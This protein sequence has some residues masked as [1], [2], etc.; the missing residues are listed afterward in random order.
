MRPSG[1]QTDWSK[2]PLPPK[3]MDHVIAGASNSNG[4]AA[5]AAEYRNMCGS[6]ATA[7]SLSSIAAD[8]GAMMGISRGSGNSGSS[9][10]LL[11]NNDMKLNHYHSGAANPLEVSSLR[12]AWFKTS[13][14]LY[15]AAKECG[16][17]PLDADAIV[18]RLVNNAPDAP[19]NSTVSSCLLWSDRYA[20]K[21]V[22]DFRCRNAN[23]H[24]VESSSNSFAVPQLHEWLMDWK[25]QRGPDW[26][27][28]QSKVVSQ[29]RQN[30][31]WMAGNDSDD[32]EDIDEGVPNAALLHG[33]PG[34]GKTSAVY[35]VASLL[36]FEVIEINAAQAR[37]G[38]AIQSLFLEATQS[39]HVDFRSSSPPH[40]PFSSSFHSLY[41]SA[42]WRGR[43]ECQKGV[44]AVFNSCG[45][46]KKR[47]GRENGSDSR[48]GKQQQLWS[49]PSSK[50]CSDSGSGVDDSR[51]GSFCANEKKLTLILFE[52]VDEACFMENYHT[53]IDPGFFAALRSMTRCAKC[54]VVM[55]AAWVPP[56]FAA[57]Q[58]GGSVGPVSSGGGDNGNS[59]GVGP[60]CYGSLSSGFGSC[61]GSTG[62]GDGDSG[63]G[64]GIFGK[65]RRPLRA[66][67]VS[68]RP[69][70]KSEVVL[71][72]SAIL[73]AEAKRCEKLHMML[74]SQG[75]VANVAEEK[76]TRL[77]ADVENATKL[78]S[79]NKR[80]GKGQRTS[81]RRGKDEAAAGAAAAATSVAGGAAAAKD[82]DKEATF[83][84]PILSSDQKYSMNNHNYN[85]SAASACQVMV[86][87]GVQA[88]RGIV[89]MNHG[90]MRACLA[91]AMVRV[92][93]IPSITGAAG[94]EE[95]AKHFEATEAREIFFWPSPRPLYSQGNDSSAL[96]STCRISCNYGSGVG[97][98]SG[99]GGSSTTQRVLCNILAD[100]NVEEMDEDLGHKFNLEPPMVTHVIPFEGQLDGGF[101]IT[102]LGSGFADAQGAVPTVATPATTTTTSTAAAAAATTATAAAIPRR[103]AARRSYSMPSQVAVLSMPALLPVVLVGGVACSDVNVVADDVITATL[104][105]ADTEGT[106]DVVIIPSPVEKGKGGYGYRFGDRCGRRSDSHLSQRF[107]G[108]F[109]YF[110]TLVSDDE[111]T[112]GTGEIEKKDIKREKDENGDSDLADVATAV[113]S[114][115]VNYEKDTALV[116]LCWTNTVQQQE[117]RFEAKKDR[118]EVMVDEE[119]EKEIISSPQLSQYDCN[120]PVITL[121]ANNMLMA[122][123]S[124]SNDDTSKKNEDDAAAVAAAAANKKEKEDLK[125]NLEAVEKEYAFCSYRRPKWMR[126]APFVLFGTTR[127]N[128][129]QMKESSFRRSRNNYTEG[130]NDKSNGE[131]IN[132]SSCSSGL[133]SLQVLL[134]SYSNADMLLF[135]I[136]KLSEVLS[137][138]DIVDEVVAL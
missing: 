131:G 10:P 87:G 113:S 39:R 34:V 24:K 77:D 81:K 120:P 106:V 110:A 69:P 68:F 102:I 14:V 130:R 15:S 12:G 93:A 89:Q 28:A 50:K 67:V 101:T 37:S 40:T 21:T 108:K 60:F 119:E 9:S 117:G 25:Q 29:Q 16:V 76:G 31:W 57:S 23:Y 88:L 51:A 138:V 54:P 70:P 41:S 46:G 84:P 19:T 118:I 73:V 20:P 32:E 92:R 43:S 82:E 64:G 6:T 18:E 103:G 17:T 53:D 45:D 30:A 132:F 86:E 128:Q 4:V 75:A 78:K 116:K 98:E 97:T 134:E 126:R 83:L 44:N 5:S 65:R 7:L 80:K 38:S 59:G 114:K 111:E 71:R 94:E 125:A 33:P 55:T 11:P 72:L 85:V 135:E 136:S 49:V 63:A 61:S 121:A 58:G 48:S 127:T 115:K 137:W 129:T 47:K 66:R 62:Y 95:D 26:L 90:D 52:E 22:E 79:G 107:N 27:A 122:S 133:C 13:S 35:A 96:L 100:E 1:A 99:S 2:V 74:S 104:P 109:S 56:G 42:S 3:K 36:G 123:S 112:E 105:P 8:D 91:A 124:K